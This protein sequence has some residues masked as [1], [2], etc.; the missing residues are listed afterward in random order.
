MLGQV[1]KLNFIEMCLKRI[2]LVTNFQKSPS[3]RDSPP[4]APLNVQ[5]WEAEFT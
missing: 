3:A 5:F 2:I 4:P 1:F